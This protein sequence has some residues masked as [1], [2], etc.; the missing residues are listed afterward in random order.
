M[1]EK[2]QYQAYLIRFQRHDNQR[3]WRT[4]L[5]NAQTN[6]VYHFA[7]ES[8]ALRFILNHLSPP[9]HESSCTGGSTT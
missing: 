5:T 4:T 3:Q 2:K 1:N 9:P 7:N 8:E 6:E